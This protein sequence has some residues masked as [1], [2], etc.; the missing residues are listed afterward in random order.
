MHSDS[1]HFQYCYVFRCLRDPEWCFAWDN[2]Y[3]YPFFFSVALRFNA[4]H[5]LLILEVSRSHTTTR[6]SQNSGRVISSSHRPL[7]DNTQHSQQTNIHVP[8]GIWTH[9][10]SRRAA[11]DL[12]LGP[13]GHWDRLLVSM[14]MENVKSFR[15]LLLFGCRFEEGGCHWSPWWWSWKPSCPGSNRCPAEPGSTRYVKKRN[16]TWFSSV[17]FLCQYFAGIFH[18]L[19]LY[20]SVAPVHFI[21]MKHKQLRPKCILLND[22]LRC[23][24]YVASV[25]YE[26]TSV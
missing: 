26:W 19:C 20:L 15:S 9:D 24:Y 21:T 3:W 2:I 13:R 25:I 11:T 5:G 8:S 10:L 22:A 14:I 4:G 17:T 18:N 12:R 6:H 23:S 16:S 7:P 1:L